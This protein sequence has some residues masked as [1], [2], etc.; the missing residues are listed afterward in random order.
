MGWF[1][2]GGVLSIALGALLMVG[3]PA[4]SL[5]ALGT[6][7]GVNLLFSGG[8]HLGLGV[9]CRSRRTTTTANETPSS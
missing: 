8:V 7:L 3:W 6:L 5:W 4:T 9:A 2:L 1:R